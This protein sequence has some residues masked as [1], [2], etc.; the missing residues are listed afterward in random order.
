MCAV[1]TPRAAPTLF[2]PPPPSYPRPAAGISMCAAPTYRTHPNPLRAPFSVIPA[3]RRGYLDVRGTDVP[4]H[5]PTPFTPLF[6]RPKLD[7]GPM[8]RL[9]AARRSGVP[10]ERALAAA[11]TLGAANG[12]GLRPQIKF[13]ATDPGGGRWEVDT[14]RYPRRSAGM[15]EKGAR[16]PVRRP[17]L[18][19]GAKRRWSAARGTGVSCER[20]LAGHS[21]LWCCERGWAWAPNQVWGDGSWGR[22]LETDRGRFPLGGGNDGARDTGRRRDG[23]GRSGRWRWARR[24]TRGGARV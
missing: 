20:A 5:L 17:K 18:D 22:A 15:T 24:D 1:P 3:L 19:L 23:R 4:H 8:R 21:G 9:L 6:R 12:V 16:P 10:C 7:L 14:S 2:A 13:G 11:R